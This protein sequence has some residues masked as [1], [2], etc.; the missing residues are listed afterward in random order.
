MP[1][2]IYIGKN[3]K[4]L[5][6][7][8]SAFNIDNDAFVTLFNFYVWRGTV[9]K[10]RGTD[11]LGRLQRQVSISNTPASW[12]YQS[13]PLVAGSVNLFTGIGV[14]I[15][16]EG[17]AIVPGTI[18]IVVN[19]VLYTDPAGDGVLVGGA[20]GDINYATGVITIV[21]GNGFLVT[22]TFSYYPALPVMG[23]EDFV[24]NNGNS[25]FPFLLAFDT[26]YAY[27]INAS[28]NTFYTVNYYKT[29]VN[30]V[31]WTGTDYQQFW[32]TNYQS[33]FWAT[34]GKPGLHALAIVSIV[35][36]SATVL[37]IVVTNTPG[38]DSIL[39]GDLIWTNE[40]TAT[41]TTNPAGKEA[42]VNHLT[43]TVT[44]VVEAP[45]GTYTLTVTFAG[46][47][48]IDPA[49][50]TAGIYTNGIIQLLVN[51]LPD[52]DGIRWYDGDPTNATGLPVGNG[53]GWV[54]FAPP[55]S[56]LPFG[57]NSQTP[58]IYYLVGA[59]AML[60]FKDRLLF[61]GVSIQAVGGN[62]ITMAMQ[63]VVIW[64]W[65][66]TPYYAAP[67]PTN[68]SASET[69]DP[70]AWFVDQ[71]GKGGY[72][73]AGI[74]QPMLTFNNN[75]D[76]L[77]IGFGGIGRK[78][79]FVYTG[80]DL[81]PFLFYS[82]NSEL[83]SAS[84]FSSIT[85][86]RGGIDI[87]AYGITL[88]TQQ[89][90]ERIDL[91]IPDEVFTIQAA[92]N[93]NAR[94]N[95]VR[96]FFREWI[97]FSYP[98]GQGDPL[99]GSWT[100][101]TRTFMWNYRDNTWAIFKE[102]YTHHGTFR[103]DEGYTW[104]TIKVDS[105]DDWTEPWDS[106][107]FAAKF[108]S[109]IA[110]NPQGYV[111]ILDQ[112]TEESPSGQIQGI[113]ASGTNTRINSVN[114]CVELND[115][116]YFTDSMGDTFLNGQIG[117]VIQ[118][119]NADFFVVDI[120]FASTG[121]YIGGGQFTRLC[122]PLLQTKQFPVYWD[123]GLGVRLCDQKYLFDRTDESQVTAVIY[124]SQDPDTPYNFGPIFPDEN[125]VNTG[126]IYTDVVVTCPESSNL[127]LLPYRTNLQMPTAATQ[128]QIWHRMS[129]SLVGNSF[130]I[131]ITLSEDQMRNLTYAQD[132]IVLQGMLLNCEPGPM[133][134]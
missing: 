9:P 131:G 123:K 65:N 98:Y 88:T 106:G 58:D 126:L 22:G 80:N 133:L 64:S 118:A 82:I 3:T 93:G 75:E 92:N 134:S 129:T 76:V 18:N 2:T 115:F 8:F 67:V 48:I 121:T 117:K 62:L 116:L 39:I 11:L 38:S 56:N 41:S 63:D 108:P 54:N 33:A 51:S 120:L 15:T 29:T 52:Q 84:T 7:Y 25:N 78:T 94:V 21:G 85:V 71:T 109:I 1:D 87:G 36:V 124:L 50:G 103:V 73:P 100:F 19:G 95:A 61:F 101:P 13:F 30:P 68:Q 91:D 31:Y 122:R 53:L 60:P 99:E 47:T 44:N 34:N 6:R 43:G 119:N 128:S 5:N 102:N 74:S 55:L 12:Q 49:T 110:G 40:I 27:Q 4:G 26:V 90:C 81:Q 20:G 24:S 114:H 113:V 132:E 107:T 17:S 10:K 77:L 45:P 125:V 57:I 105:W 42:S 127:G 14:D 112:G 86:D 28:T 69:F 96:D 46:A 111:Q 130:Q 59:R 16:E 70:T 66:G 89:S 79:R 32:S 83:P 104:D 97:Y 35:W 72:L 23:L 37:T